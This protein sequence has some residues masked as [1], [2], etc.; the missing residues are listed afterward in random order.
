[1]KWTYAKIQ[2]YV[3]RV[4]RYALRGGCQ[5]CKRLTTGLELIGIPG[6]TGL[7]RGGYGLS[8]IKEDIRER[9]L[10]CRSCARGYNKVAVTKLV[11]GW[12]REDH[13]VVVEEEVVTPEVDKREW[14]EDRKLEYCV[15]GRTLREVL[16][17]GSECF[18]KGDPV[19]EEISRTY[20]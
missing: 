14:S 2:E 18:E 4:R 9:G 8:R 11:E 16:E 5:K 12:Q 6:L 13:L 17:R 1:M 19:L 15:A 7:A 20:G 3:R 10:Y